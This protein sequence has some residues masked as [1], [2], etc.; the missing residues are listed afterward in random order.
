MRLSFPLSTFSKH[1]SLASYENIS[2]IISKDLGIQFSA[3]AIRIYFPRVSKNLSPN[4]VGKENG[5]V[6]WSFFKKEV[7]EFLSI[8]TPLLKTV[9][10]NPS[11]L[12]ESD[13]F[14]VSETLKKMC[15]GSGISTNENAEI[16][17][18]E[19]FPAQFC[20]VMKNC[21]P[22]LLSKWTSW[23]SAKEETIHLYSFEKTPGYADKEIVINQRGEWNFRSDGIDRDKAV[24][25]VFKTLPEHMLHMNSLMK[26]LQI[27]ENSKLCNGCGSSEEFE[28]LTGPNGSSIFKKKD[29]REGV[30]YEKELL[31][32][33]DCEILLKH[34]QAVSCTS[35]KD[36]RHYLRT[37]SSRTKN[38]E[39]TPSIS[40]R[41]DYRSREDLI[42]TARESSKTI[43]TLKEKLKRTSDKIDEIDVGLTSHEDLKKMFSDLYSGITENKEKRNVRLCKWENCQC[44]SQF[45]NVETLYVHCK[46]HIERID[47]SKIAPKDKTYPCKWNGC[48]KKY[49]KLKLLEQHIRD[50]TGRLNDDFLEI[51]LTDQAKALNTEPR[52]MRWHPL[53]IKWCLRIYIKS[54]GL[55]E[56][57]RNFGG[58][59]LP[60]GRLLSD[61]KNFCAPKSGWN[62]ANLEKMKTQ[63][64][65]M[66]PPNR[67]KLGG[68]VFNE[69]KIKEGL[70]F[71]SKNWELIGFTDLL[72][73]GTSDR[74]TEKASDNLATHILQVFF[75]S[76]FFNFDYPCAYFLTKETTA[77]QLNRIFWMGVSMLH[78]FGFEIMFCCCDGA[79]SNRSFILLNIDDTSKSFCINVFSGRRIFFFSDPPHLIKKLRN[80]IHKSGFKE[81]S[82]RYTRTLFLDEQYIL[83]D[84]IYSVYRR[85]IRRP[86]YVTDL[87]KAHVEIDPISKM[88]V[89]LAVQTLSTKVSKEMEKSAEKE[90]TKQTRRYIENCKSLWKVFNYPKPLCSLN[91]ER[92]EE[93][94]NV[95]KF[96]EQWRIWLT[97]KFNKKE[98]QSRH[99][100]SW[101]TKFDLDVS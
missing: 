79:S 48:S 15:D 16:C 45:E 57:F 58:L 95:V 91:D 85:E 38:N 52:Q 63:F 92:I 65:Q 78:I 3:A 21:S 51:L 4:K 98:E 93:L 12:T 69:V 34:D 99:F 1:H 66:K 87:R 26:V 9:L 68:L 25:K 33:A 60:S 97:T 22:H 77:I 73:D 19:I 27:T 18:N 24:I 75:R 62:M 94:N 35:C 47:T 96:F 71:D 89:K 46:Q 7:E 83:W 81:N 50:H 28:H 84:H 100:I 41:Y 82:R 55:Y 53:V 32:S 20:D 70:V 90:K 64:K 56:D 86:L 49:A 29:G 37:I 80:N 54:H 43:K 13:M 61:Y 59:K 11:A 74:N 101:Q 5:M 8:A 67:A 31:R 88:R 6:R 40:T 30:T 14:F 42:A 23:Y 39:K 17:H 2:I 72:G 10:D 76:M 44:K 36:C